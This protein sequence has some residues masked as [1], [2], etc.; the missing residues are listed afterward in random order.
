MIKLQ[1]SLRL[2]ILENSIVSGNNSN[3]PSSD[4]GFEG[5]IV[6]VEVVEVDVNAGLDF[7]G[8]LRVSI[9][10]VLLVAVVGLDSVGFLLINELFQPS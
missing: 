2:L 3:S 5:F 4:I 8:E 10:V 7:A 6:V 9:V 1:D